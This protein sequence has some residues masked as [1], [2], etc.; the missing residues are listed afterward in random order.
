MSEVFFKTVIL[1]GF[2]L[3]II[4]VLGWFINLFKAISVVMSGSIDTEGALHM[5][6]VFLV[7]LGSVM[8]LFF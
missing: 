3:A 5:V 8:G 1:T 4:A 2:A 6:G 7:P